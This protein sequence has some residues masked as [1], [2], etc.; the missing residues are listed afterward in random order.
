MRV[1][2][3]VWLAS[4]CARFCVLRCGTCCD[5]NV[6]CDGKDG[7]CSIWLVFLLTSAGCIAVGADCWRRR[8]INKCAA[9]KWNRILI[10]FLIVAVM[11]LG[12]CFCTRL[13]YC[14]ITRW[15]VMIG[16]L[17]LLSPVSGAIAFWFRMLIWRT[18]GLW[19]S[20]RTGG[21][22]IDKHLFV[23]Y[24]EENETVL[25]THWLS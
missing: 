20:H 25:C 1:L 10:L 18:V 2:W 16:L 21:G 12:P 5:V 22:G 9:L 3:Y 6:G 14:I 8:F 13:L 19:W 4:K 15:L 23:V 24:L 17:V 7:R 11:C